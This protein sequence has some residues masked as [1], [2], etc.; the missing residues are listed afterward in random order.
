MGLIQCKDVCKSFGEKIAL[1]NVSVDIPKGK[2]F[3]LLGPNGAGKIILYLQEFG[4]SF[5][6]LD[7]MYH[8]ALTSLFLSRAL[9]AFFFFIVYLFFF[10]IIYYTAC[11]RGAPSFHLLPSV[12]GK[13][14][15]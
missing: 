4:F 3:G 6:F 15:C 1:D 5:V 10:I 8:F 2:I 9:P 14:G 7:G 12:E 13:S 11:H